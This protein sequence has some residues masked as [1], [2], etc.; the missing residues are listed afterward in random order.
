MNFTT[1]GTSPKWN[2]TVFVFMSLIYFI[3][4]NILNTHSCCSIYQNF[5]P[6]LCWVI[7]S[8]I[9]VH[10]HKPWNIVLVIHLSIDG[11]LY[12]FHILAVVNSAAVN[13]GMQVSLQDPAF[14][15][16]AYVPRNGITRSYGGSIFSV[17]R[18][19]HNVFQSICTVL[20]LVN[21]V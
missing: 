1:L 9:Y 2:H 18:S 20:H 6:L 12:Y 4:H 14:N 3:W 10:T 7:F 21:D 16:F 11:H 19:L 5:F 8:G 17:S 13:K 15:S